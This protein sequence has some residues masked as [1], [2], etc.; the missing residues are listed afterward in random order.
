MPHSWG[1]IPDFNLWVNIEKKKK[2]KPITSWPKHMCCHSN[3]CWYVTQWRTALLEKLIFTHIDRQTEL[4]TLHGSQGLIT[5]PYPQPD[6]LLH[7]FITYI[8]LARPIHVIWFSHLQLD[9]TNCLMLC[10]L[11]LMHT[12]VYLLNDDIS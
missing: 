7:T 5:G 10:Q 12:F 11:Y 1:Q 8:F 3:T 2:K 9:L 4:P 6:E